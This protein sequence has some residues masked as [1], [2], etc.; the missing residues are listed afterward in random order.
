[1]ILG[2][3]H[4]DAWLGAEVRRGNPKHPSFLKTSFGW[5]AVGGWSR[6]DSNNIACCAMQVDDE[7][8][9]K[10]FQKIFNHDFAPVSEAE[11]GES[12]ENKEAIRQLNDS[13][14]FDK[15]RGKY[16]IGLLWRNGREAACQTLNALDSQQM[17]LKRLQGMIHRFRRNDERKQRVFKEMEKFEEKGY[18]DVIDNFNDDSRAENPRWYLPIHVVE[19]N[20]KTR[21]CHDAKASVKNTSLND[22]LLGS[23][24]LLNSL[25]GILLSFRT[26]K[27]AF[28]TDISAYFHQ[29]L[30]DERDADVFRYFWFA[31]QSMET[32]KTLRFNA[33]IFGSGASSLV[34]SFVLRYHSERIKSL[35]PQNVY[36]TIKNKIY[37]DDGSGGADTIEE[38]LRLKEDLKTAL[39]MGGFDLAKW[40][41][42]DPR[43]LVGEETAK[44]GVI[45]DERMEPTKVLGVGW[46]PEG[47]FFTF[48]FSDDIFL[49]DI[50]TP[51][52]LVSISASLFDPSG[53]LS[54][55]NLIARR[56]LQRA[57]A[58]NASWDSPL[59][60]DVKREF[61]KWVASIPLLA[62]LK[63]QRWWN[64]KETEDVESE[65]GHIFSDASVSGYAAVGH[66]RVTGVS[67]AV[68]VTIIS[69]KSHVVPLNPAKTSHHNSIPRL[70]LAAGVKAVDIHLFIESSLK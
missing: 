35:F 33:H 36:D 34:T 57:T 8:L 48:F 23:P 7:A 24:N 14:R 29:V 68:H 63:I 65:Q 69:A 45:G 47:D 67:G 1:M 19:K 55:F 9:R 12:V 38:A 17:A 26:K 11:V 50:N 42:N 64:T 15:K 43:L 18:A 13:I 61:K 52:D 2:V 22:L 30:I 54:P 62:R 27:I 70:E 10:D 60:E 59:D 51:R 31:D 25:P 39:K 56:L 5:T 41:S 21:I 4:A 46:E 3:A 37:V 53:F 44:A 66:R 28:M 58:N 6:K 49:R 40:K 32:Y 16:M 20:G